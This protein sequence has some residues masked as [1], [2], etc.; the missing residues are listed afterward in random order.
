MS[1]KTAGSVRA[2]LQDLKNAVDAATNKQTETFT[3]AISNLVNSSVA[4]EGAANFINYC[5]LS[6][7][8]ETDDTDAMVEL[9][10]IT[11][12]SITTLKIPES[13]E[14]VKFKV[15]ENC[16]NLNNLTIPF[17]GVRKDSSINDP[18]TNFGHIF[19]AKS[20]IEHGNCVPE[21]LKSVTITGSTRIHEYAFAE[22]ANIQ[23]IN[24][25]GGVTDIKDYAFNSCSSLTNITIPNTITYIGICVF[26]ACDSLTN[27]TFNGTIAQWNAIEKDS[28]WNTN[29]PDCTITCTDGTIIEHCWVD[30]T[31]LTPKTCINCNITEGSA[32]GHDWQEATC[33]KPKTCS[34]CKTTEGSARGHMWGPLTTVIAATC[35]QIGAG[36]K[37]CP[38]CGVVDN[39]VVIP[40][41]GH[42]YVAA[43]YSWNSTNTECTA[44]RTCKNDISHKET[45]TTNKVTSQVTKDP[46]CT[47]TGTRVYYATFTS[48]WATKQ[49]KTVIIPKVSHIYSEATC[50][51]P[52]TCT[53]CGGTDGSALGHAWQEATCTTPKTCTVCGC[54]DGSALGH[55]WQEATCTKPKTCSRCK[56]TEGSALGHMWG[57]LTTVIAATC[58]TDGAG[59]KTCPVCGTVDNDVVIPAFGH[60]YGSASYSWNNDNSECTATRTCKKDISH[61]ETVTVY[62]TS[63]VTIEP[64]CTTTGT[65]TYYATF[66]KDWTRNQTKKVSIP[67]TG[68]DYGTPNYNWDDGD[69]CQGVRTCKTDASHVQ[70]ASGNITSAIT[71]P[72]TCTSTGIITYTATFPDFGNTT[73][74]Y[75]ESIPALGHDFVYLGEHKSPTCTI[76]GESMYKCN[77]CSEI[78]YGVI[79]AAHHWEEPY[80]HIYDIHDLLVIAHRYCP[81]CG[82]TEEAYALVEETIQEPTCEDDGEKLI[83]ITFAEDWMTDSSSTEILPALG[84]EFVPH[85]YVWA[86]D[87]SSCTANLGCIRCAAGRR[88]TATVTSQITKE[89]TCTETGIRTYTARFT[90]EDCSTQ[91]KTQPVSATGHDWQPASCEVAKYCADCGETEGSAIGHAWGAVSYDWN[92]IDDPDSDGYY[93]CTASRQCANADHRQTSNCIARISEQVSATCTTDGYI[94]YSASF[95]ES[96]ATAQTKQ[97]VL[98][99]RGHNWTAATCTAP[100]TCSACGTTEGEALSHSW[101]AATCTKPKTCSVCGTTEGS[102]P[103]HMWGPLKTVIAATCTQNGAGRKTCNVCGAVDNDV[104][105][106][107]FGHSWQ[108][109][110]TW[111]EFKASCLANR[112]CKECNYSEEALTTSITSEVTQTPTCYDDGVMTYTATFT[113]DWAE[114]QT[115]TEAIS[116]RG[117]SYSDAPEYTWA[118]DYSSCTATNYCIYCNHKDTAEAQVTDKTITAATCTTAGTKTYTAT[119]NK[120]WAYNQTKTVAIPATGHAWFENG[121][122]FYPTCTNV[123][124]KMLKCGVCSETGYELVPE[125]GH[126]WQITY[127]WDTYNMSCTATKACKNTCKQIEATHTV[128]ITS[129]VTKEVT[130]YADGEIVY[131]A[132]FSDVTWGATTQNM[133]E[134][135]Y[136]RGHKYYGDTEYEWADDYSSCTGTNYCSTG[137]GYSYEETTTNITS[138]VTKA[139]TCTAE[140]ERKYTANFKDA[141]LYDSIKE[142]IPKVAHNWNNTLY[143]W[144]TDL[145]SVQSDPRLAECVASRTCSTCGSVETA[146]GY[147]TYK[148]NTGEEPTTSASGIASYTATFNEVWARSQATTG[149]VH[150][151]L[152]APDSHGVGL[153]GT[154]PDTGEKIYSVDAKNDNEFLVVCFVT[155]YDAD[156]VAYAS[157]QYP[158][159]AATYANG[160]LTSSTYLSARDFK[161]ASS[162]NGGTYTMQF[163]NAYG[164]SDSDK[165]TGSIS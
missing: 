34:V 11:D 30:A 37:S 88:V 92:W 132:D 99:A 60:S 57:P 133:T 71:T 121:Y 146:A 140:G 110:Y 96:W 101:Q 56:L 160:K 17:I 53:V 66:N 63:Q 5:K 14:A 95:A 52:K 94:T 29:A 111:D 67:A 120:Y 70:Y 116:S 10:E 25:L 4:N 128:D 165:V 85:E 153:Y 147:V 61:K 23:T 8:P 124:E 51:T 164:M 36:R 79:P 72:A 115:V 22:C 12:T 16:N 158:M 163:G 48:T 69:A 143:S 21:A 93:I 62:S 31:C 103:G 127:D 141:M 24:L 47:A 58:T 150:K 131:T 113:K 125:L 45:E 91:T 18:D 76:D 39:D 40:A 118:D 139:A 9:S 6:V 135:Q 98:N 144:N 157:R 32:L 35:T 28:K 114:D 161:V 102:A 86:D 145:M 100:K 112:T 2:K 13:V 80:Y 89:P 155:L 27:I 123:G 87:L 136:S 49:T 154:D 38:V 108:V 41:K 73:S 77:R 126:D 130:C 83:T 74:T 15:L 104:V 90:D 107:A 148:Y 65:K 106:P 151:K 137:C 78:E 129:E 152:I 19:G 55:N 105:I 3:D 142:V 134:I 54:T 82:T 1:I 46:T 156:G 109:T 149:V 33:T 138:T 122:H 117:H 75:T 68:H 159:D 20:H 162:F 119:F 64:T 84:C 50:T 43:T 59:R 42:S 97:V 81:S 7:L 44:T 26:Q